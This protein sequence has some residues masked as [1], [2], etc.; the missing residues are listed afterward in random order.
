[1]KELATD[2]SVGMISFARATFD[3]SLA[4]TLV[5]DLRARLIERGFTVRGPDRFVSDLDEAG[6]AAGELSDDPPHLLLI[7]QATFSDSTMA[8]E[9]ARKVDSPLLLWAVPE[10]QTGGRLRLNSLCGINLAAHAL[11]RSGLRYNYIHAPVD[12][13]N[14]MDRLY[15]LAAAGRVRRLL[16]RSRIGRVGEHP[17]GFD[18]C[19]FDREALKSRFGTDIVQIDLD[20]VFRSVRHI[21]PQ[22]IDNLMKEI[23]GKVDGLDEL[24]QNGVR[25]TLATYLVLKGIAG[26]QNLDGLAVRCWPQFF[27]ELGC[28]A[29][30][31]MSMLSDESIPCSCETDINGTITQFILQSLSGEPAFGTDLVSV[32]EKEDIAVLWH[33]GL[34]PLSMADPAKKPRGTIHS[35]RQMPLL[36]D[37]SLKPGKV[38]LARI[39][40]DGTGYR[41]VVGSGEIIE[42][43]QSFSGTSGVIRFDR[44]VGEILDTI[45]KEGL[46]HHLSIT[47]GDHVE[48]LCALAE[49]LD[50]PVLPLS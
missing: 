27:T 2:I 38:T 40:D 43:P 19:K 12:D 35:N 15:T 25:G 47:Y 16:R 49:M 7:F 11:T 1:M 31:A 17:E 41:L 13:V 8:V 36:M 46:E 28:A 21:N 29:C 42:A 5:A 10:E 22:E 20:E 4:E 24:D 44:P 37:F 45:M 3:T 50:L 39:S 34:A 9:V 18:S 48:S 14:A 32:D 23:G 26:E 6:R 33:C 30:G